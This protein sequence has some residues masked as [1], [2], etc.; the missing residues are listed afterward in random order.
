MLCSCHHVRLYPAIVHRRLDLEPKPD[1]IRIR[2]SCFFCYR[3]QT[4]FLPYIELSLQ[5]IYKLSNSVPWPFVRSP[6]MWTTGLENSNKLSKHR[7]ITNP[8]EYWLGW[9]KNT[10]SNFWRKWN[11][12]GWKRG[13]HGYKPFNNYINSYI[14]VYTRLL[15]SPYGIFFL[16]LCRGKGVMSL[17]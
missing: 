10:I 11:K 3:K 12:N 17:V 7:M 1:E 8:V 5:S 14:K 6:N 2:F 15:C 16:F 9:T 4:T 13:G